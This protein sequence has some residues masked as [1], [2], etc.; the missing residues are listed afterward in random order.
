MVD[1]RELQG[2]AYRAEP[3]LFCSYRARVEKD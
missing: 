1:G 3:K 2:V